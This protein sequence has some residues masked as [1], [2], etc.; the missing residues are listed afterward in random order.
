MRPAPAVL[1]A[2]SGERNF[3]AISRY[4]NW[5]YRH[6]AHNLSADRAQSNLFEMERK[7]NFCPPI[8]L[9]QFV[10]VSEIEIDAIEFQHTR[11]RRY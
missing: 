11:D 9:M 8:E 10:P 1:R 7:D 5:R 4:G 6:S 2:Q 3:I